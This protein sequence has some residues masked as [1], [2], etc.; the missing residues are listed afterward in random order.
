[1]ATPDPRSGLA[2]EENTF[3]AAPRWTREPSESIVARLAYHH[4]RL[5]RHDIEQSTTSL[6]FQGAFNKLYAVECPKGPFL[7]RVTLP[8]DPVYKTLSETA[9]LRYVRENTSIPVP[10]VIASDP[11]SDNELG[12]KWILMER[13]PGKPLDDVWDSLDWDKKVALVRDVAVITE[14]MRG[15]RSNAIG[16]LFE[17]RKLAEHAGHA[18]I[19][20]ERELVIDRLVS[21]AFFWKTRFLVD[22]PRG[23]FRTTREWLEARFR[24]Q[25]DDVQQ[26]VNDADADKDDVEETEEVR[27]LLA[28]LR[29]H[30]D[31]F[32]PNNS[33]GSESF[34]LYHDD[35]S[36]KNL[37]VDDKGALKALVD[38]ECVSTCP[39]WKNY[40]A[41][42]FLSSATRET[43]PDSKTYHYDEEGNIDELFHQHEEEYECTRLRR[44]F[45]AMMATVMPQWDIG[46]KHA[47][48]SMDFD[49]AL[50]NCDGGF[51]TRMVEVWLDRLEQGGEY[52]SLQRAWDEYVGI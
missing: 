15:Q 24:L 34:A 12:Y 35:I 48:E 1:M 29:E 11:S 30:L 45:M 44:I 49:Q 14:E 32:F 46:R 5:S 43:K 19:G 51:G 25:D 36:R 21:M 52:V 23:P 41:P 6:E 7:M 10:S 2:W 9:T 13:V 50:A 22:V 28:R 42:A 40:Q 47:Q 8:V 27:E 3:G 16:S 38:W 26:V 17:R 31:R 4:L 37:I 39:I 20:T 33:L 18:D